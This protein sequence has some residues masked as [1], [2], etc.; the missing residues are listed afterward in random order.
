MFLAAVALSA[1]FAAD[2]WCAVAGV[3]AN[4]LAAPLALYDSW[5]GRYTANLVIGIVGVLGP[6]LAWVVPMLA[7]AGLLGALLLV[8]REHPDAAIGAVALL[9]IVAPAR[10]QDFGWPTGATVV[11]VV[12]GASVVVV[13]STVEVVESATEVAR[14]PAPLPEPSDPPL[15]QAATRDAA[16]RVM[17]ETGCA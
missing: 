17:L 2:D 6:Q 14:P 8:L 3:R 7:A 1:K 12:E 5:S 4:G 11:E 9:V 16:V 15:E 10:W 13:S